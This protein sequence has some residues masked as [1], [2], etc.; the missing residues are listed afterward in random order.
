MFYFH[1]YVK[2]KVDENDKND[3]VILIN[4]DKKNIYV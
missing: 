1:K 2:N 4:V 3:L